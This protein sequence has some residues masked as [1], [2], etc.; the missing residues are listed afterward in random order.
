MKFAQ[1]QTQSPALLR[2]DGSA[3]ALEDLVDTLVAAIRQHP[4]FGNVLH[5]VSKGDSTAMREAVRQVLLGRESARDLTCVARNL[6][7]LLSGR[8]A[9]NIRPFGAWFLGHVEE[10]GSRLFRDLVARRIAA[11]DIEIA[12]APAKFRASALRIL[13]HF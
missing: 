13:S 9:A 10:S 7:R 2:D 5:H 4:H 11:V 12:T 3:V 8:G 6:V 1:L